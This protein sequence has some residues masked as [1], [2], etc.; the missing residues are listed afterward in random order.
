M[1]ESERERDIERENKHR[2]TSKPTNRQTHR[3]TIR[4]THRGGVDVGPLVS[5]HVRV[6]APFILSLRETETRDQ[7]RYRDREN[8]NKQPDKQTDTDKQAKIRVEGGMMNPPPFPL[9]H[10]RGPALYLSVPQRQGQRNQGRERDNQ[11]TNQ[12]DNQTNRNT[13]TNRQAGIRT[14]GGVMDP[15]SPLTVCGG[16][17]RF[18]SLSLCFSERDTHRNQSRDG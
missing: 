7:G 4:Y 9:T 11:M 5:L 3:Q 12:P 16:W 14:D 17:G 2:R 10:S 8:E 1:R 6:L 15:P 18:R 13:Y